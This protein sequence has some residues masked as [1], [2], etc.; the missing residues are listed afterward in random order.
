MHVKWQRQKLKSEFNGVENHLV[1][2]LEDISAQGAQ[3]GDG[4]QHRLGSIKEQYLKTKVTNAREF[5]QGLFWA[6]VDNN[7]NFLAFSP[8]VRN[9]IEC[10]ILEE[11]PRPGEDWAL[12]GVTC[13]P[14]FDP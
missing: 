14:R 7:L 9:R 11:V 8:D 2:V 13:I 10:Q 3:K 6:T 1:A 4:L 5:H 12:W